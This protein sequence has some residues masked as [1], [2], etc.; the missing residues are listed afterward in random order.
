MTRRLGPY[1]G[2]PAFLRRTFVKFMNVC[3]DRP[4]LDLL[5]VA[6]IVGGHA[7]LVYR[8][9]TGNVLHWA[10]Q[11][12]RLAVYAAGAG[13]MS[14][15]AGF[16]GTAIAQYGSSSGPVV[17][18]IR[19]AHGLA[20]RRNWLN[21]AGWL[22]LGTVL[23]LV[24]MSIDTKAGPRGSQWIFE[25][26]LGLAILKFFRLLFLFGLILSS[27]DQGLSEPVSRRR[28]EL[29]TPPR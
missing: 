23:C 25:V 14:L 10:D 27:L 20:I 15:I 7:L 16:T 12:Q 19:S 11:S 26:A 2:W 22:L 17:S 9:H 28:I 4:T 1:D 29:K 13:M 6:V 3:T 18:A 8:F 5:V 21:I 24:A